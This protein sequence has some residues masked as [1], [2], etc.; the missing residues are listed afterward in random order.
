VAREQTLI[1]GR[2]RRNCLRLQQDGRTPLHKACER[3]CLAV[4]VMLLENKADVNARDLVRTGSI[5][6]ESV[7]RRGSCEFVWFPFAWL[8]SLNPR[9]ARF[10]RSWTARRCTRRRSARRWTSCACWR[11]TAQ[12]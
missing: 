3:G 12:T 9:V 2:S 1:P 7:T 6:S 11:C 8:H 5:E 10:P 4:G